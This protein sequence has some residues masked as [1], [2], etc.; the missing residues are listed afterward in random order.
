MELGGLARR[1]PTEHQSEELW[2]LPG[3]LQVPDATAAEA[4]FAG[5]AF[6]LLLEHRGAQP[7]K[8]D[9]GERCQERVL[10]FEV[11]VRG[12]RGDAKVPPELPQGKACRALFAE[13]LL[14]C[15]QEG[16]A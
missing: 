15:Q 9:G 12:A 8:T 5:H 14:G 1:H 2:V 6:L 4:F 10:V 13:L 7:L 11:T 16:I 3:E